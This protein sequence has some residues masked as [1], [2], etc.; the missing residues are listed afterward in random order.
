MPK[1]SFP[2]TADTGC[3]FTV[4]EGGAT[5]QVTTTAEAYTIQRM[6]PNGYADCINPDTGTV[7]TVGTTPSNVAMFDQGTYQIT[8]A[9]TTAGE[10]LLLEGSA[11]P[12]G[13]S[14]WS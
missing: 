10:A 2:A 3:K 8:K 7:F 9:L 12:V 6:G 5:I 1:Y 14:Y 4:G 11:T 13:G